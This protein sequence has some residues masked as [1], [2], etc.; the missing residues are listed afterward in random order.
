MAKNSHGVMLGIEIKVARIRA[1]L[2]QKELAELLYVD[3]AIVS[4]IETDKMQVSEE[5]LRAIAQITGVK[6][7]AKN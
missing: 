7:D 6:I 3:R 4:R 5:R 2:T 1:Q